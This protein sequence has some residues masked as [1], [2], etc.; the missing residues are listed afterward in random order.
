M[1][2]QEKINWVLEQLEDEESKFILKKRWEFAC[3]NDYRYLGE[4]ID[5][6]VTEFSEY[7]WNPDKQEEMIQFIRKSGKG[8]IIFGAGYNGKSAL[9]LCNKRGISVDYFCDNDLKKQNTKVENVRVIS[10]KE[11]LKESLVK[12]YV[13]IIGARF[14]YEEIYDSLIDMGVPAHNIF[15]FIELGFSSEQYF[16]PVLNFGE[17]EVFVDGGSYDFETSEVFL[18]K[19]KESGGNCKKIY[20][21]E[22]DR[23]NYEK[24][25]DKANRL[26]LNNVSLMCAGLWKED[27]YVKFCILGNASSRIL[28]AEREDA[29]RVKVSALDACITEKVTFIKLDIEGAE[30]AAL[31]GAK[32][33]LLRDKPRLA[34]C[35]YH[36]KEDLW[37]IPYYIKTLIPEYKLYVRHYSNYGDE[38]VLYGVC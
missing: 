18:K 17:D 37:E 23:L 21:F 33:I 29:D 27:T 3:S 10:P 22:P 8:V 26:G 38:T 6:Y 31:Q 13:I 9:R 25:V 2:E 32:N 28:P 34:I 5:N 7:K 16:D 1:S 14:A 35:I 36:K 20:A 12:D 24:C 11:I 30:L 15:K 4:I 19:V